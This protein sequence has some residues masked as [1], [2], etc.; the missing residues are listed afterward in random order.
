M[1]KKIK[2]PKKDVLY[3]RLPIYEQNVYLFRTRKAMLKAA[4]YCSVDIGNDYLQGEVER[5]TN[6]KDGSVMFWIGVYSKK[7]HVLAHELTH[8]TFSIADW[9]GL[10][11]EPEENN[12]SA[13][14]LQGWL[15]K[16][17]WKFVR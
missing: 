3:V 1:G 14:Y 11:T 4:K 15:F 10:T 16:K 17:M 8:L 5:V 7:P 6:I 13:A 9:V 12:E 2:W